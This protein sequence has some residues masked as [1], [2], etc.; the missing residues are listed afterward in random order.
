MAA[1]PL[2]P[3][4]G[5]GP[6][7]VPGSPPAARP[8]VPQARQD[9]SPPSGG[10]FTPEDTM[11]HLCL[12][13]ALR[14]VGPVYHAAAGCRAVVSLPGATVWITP[15]E[16]YWDQDGRRVTCPAGNVPDAAI[17]LTRLAQQATLPPMTATRS[18][19]T[20]GRAAPVPSTRHKPGLGGQRHG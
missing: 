9:S 3:G 4:V 12:L 5:P 7:T 20:P 19:R 14:D 2:P 17:H 11:G 16:L 1:N 18:G 13:L 10:C 8:Y 6:V 15:R